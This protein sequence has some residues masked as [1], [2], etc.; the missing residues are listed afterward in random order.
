MTV[1]IPTPIFEVNLPESSDCWCCGGTWSIGPWTRL[2]IHVFALDESISTGVGGLTIEPDSNCPT[3]VCPHCALRWTWLSQLVP[4]AVEELRGIVDPL[5]PDE[6]MESAEDLRERLQEALKVLLPTGFLSTLHAAGLH[7]DRVTGPRWSPG[8]A[9][10]LDQI[11][12]HRDDPADG[13]GDARLRFIL[14]WYLALT[15]SPLSDEER[16]RLHE[17]TYGQKALVDALLDNLAGALVDRT[18][19][20]TKFEDK[21]TTDF[22]SALTE[23]ESGEKTGDWIWWIFPQAKGLGRTDR[24]RKYAVG[25]LD[26]AVV[27]LAHRPLGDRYCQIAD[28]VWWQVTRCGTPVR[29]LFG[30]DAKKLVSSLTL[31]RRA[32]GKCIQDGLVEYEDRAFERLVSQC[33]EILDVAATEGLPRCTRS[34]N[35][36]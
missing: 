23:I 14:N 31:F 13:T 27:Y 5:S 3:G 28:A 24:S 6:R 4:D 32:A 15:P 25:S 26:E 7:A 2:G 12:S 1:L 30:R 16:E 29:T 10:L 35:L 21:V 33:A 17:V 9:R 34:L 8:R 18:W 36:D 22:H 19:P 20:I 11:R